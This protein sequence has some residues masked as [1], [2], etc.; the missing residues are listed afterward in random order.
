M[1]PATAQT[2]IAQS[3]NDCT[4]HKATTPNILIQNAHRFFKGTRMNQQFGMF[5]VIL[6]GEITRSVCSLFNTSW[7]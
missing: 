5:V 2:Q 3:G 6:T 7:A 4:N 1:S